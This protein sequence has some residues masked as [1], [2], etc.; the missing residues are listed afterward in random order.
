M[1][2]LTGL[3]LHLANTRNSTNKARY[4]STVISKTSVSCH[5]CKGLLS[6][7]VEDHNFVLYLLDIS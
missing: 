3:T 1:C 4:G 5:H 6:H 7:V 2:P